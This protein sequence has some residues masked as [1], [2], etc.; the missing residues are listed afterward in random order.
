MST[1]FPISEALTRL[2]DHFAICEN[3]VMEAEAE[4]LIKIGIGVHLAGRSEE[5]RALNRFLA[6]YGEDAPVEF[7]CDDLEQG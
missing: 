6:L 1:Q 7:G 3:R 4:Y 2:I 5:T